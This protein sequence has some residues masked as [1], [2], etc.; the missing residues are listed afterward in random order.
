MF[1]DGAEV[2]FTVDAEPVPEVVTDYHPAKTQ[3][4]QGRQVRH[5]HSSHRIDMP[6]EKSL[7][8]G[9]IQFSTRQYLF[10]VIRC[11]AGLMDI[12]QENI[13]RLLLP[14]LQQPNIISRSSHRSTVT[15]GHRHSCT[16][17]MDTAQCELVFHVKMLM[18][19]DSVMKFR[20]QK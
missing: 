2:L 5:R 9:F 17:Q 12:L 19:Y 1:N 13:V 16:V 14:R 11:L 4:T 8:S 3:R 15:R 20:R 10:L 7:V 6:T 18:Y